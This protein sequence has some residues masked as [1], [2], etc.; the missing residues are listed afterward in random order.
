MTLVTHPRNEM[1]QRVVI[2]ALAVDDEHELFS[3]RT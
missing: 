3:F 1:P 2:G